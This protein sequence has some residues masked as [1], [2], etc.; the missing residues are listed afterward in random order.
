MCKHRRDWVRLLRRFGIIGSSR[1]LQNRLLL[2]THSRS[3][4]EEKQ[5]GNYGA[6]ITT[7]VQKASSHYL[8]PAC[9]SLACTAAL[10]RIDPTISP[11]GYNMINDD[12]SSHG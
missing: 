7:L 2:C 5:P 6:R 4:L 10:L 9:I 3:G 8:F 11:S 12:W 1:G